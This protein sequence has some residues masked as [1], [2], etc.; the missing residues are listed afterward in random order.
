MRGRHRSTS[1]QY[2]IIALLLISVSG[3]AARAQDRWPPWQSLGGTEDAARKARPK[4]RSL[5][6]VQNAAPAVDAAEK[7]PAARPGQEGA[8]SPVQPPTA[9]PE[10]EP[11]STPEVAIKTAATVGSPADG[12]YKTEIVPLIPHSNA[13]ADLRL[14]IIKNLV[15]MLSGRVLIEGGCDVDLFIPSMGST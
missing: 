15:E 11:F 2:L 1:I 5:P 13:G 4:H 14:Q 10:R 12:K 6:K 3:D 8:A 9:Q 7:N